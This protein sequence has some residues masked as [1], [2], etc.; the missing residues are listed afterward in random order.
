MLNIK[1]IQEIEEQRRGRNKDTAIN[2]TYINSGD[3]RKKFDCISNDKLLNRLLFQL[4]KK[5]L[6]HRTGTL[7]E[8]MYWIDLDTMEIVAEESTNDIEEGIFY[9]DKTKNVIKR[10]N[11][12]LT[13][14]SHPNS[15]PPSIADFNSNFDNDYVM[16][17]VICHNG[18]IYRYKAEEYVSEKYYHLTVAEHLKLGYNEFEAQIETL[19]ELQ[20]KFNIEFKE[21]TGN[22]L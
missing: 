3:F 22:D 14:H 12:L 1:Y 10:Y 20:E 16:G 7:Y 21:V 8:D 5:M 9:S 4:S 15:Y 19:K 6:L 18:K 2:H 13:I 11:N 17:I